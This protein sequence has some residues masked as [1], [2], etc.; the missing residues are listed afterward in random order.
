M[1]W[2]KNYETGNIQVDNEHK[3]IF[4][5]VQSVMEATFD[6]EES[7]IESTIDFLANY[8]VNHF[9]HEERLM[10]ESNYPSMPVHKKQHDDFVIEVLD[11]RERVK[12][13]SS[14]DKNSL[15]IKKVIVNWLVDHVLGSD[16]IMADHYRK[17]SN[18]ENK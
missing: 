13:E 16:K 15:E 6:S 17:W 10:E 7:K 18:A 1:I 9:K 8:T 12:S 14:S 4:K 3:E 5:M 2:H 11:L